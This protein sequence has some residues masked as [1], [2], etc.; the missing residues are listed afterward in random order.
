MTDQK[1]LS[2]TV[3]A[4]RAPLAKPMRLA[5]F[6]I[7]FGFSVALATP[8]MAQDVVYQSHQ[9]VDFG[10][11]TI[12]GNL[13]KPDGAWLDARKKQKHRKLIRIRENFRTEIL[14]SVRAL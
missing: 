7:G 14:Q 8:A 2:K 1:S 9:V 11:D 5:L 10:D 13:S 12:D 4:E 3:S 6:A